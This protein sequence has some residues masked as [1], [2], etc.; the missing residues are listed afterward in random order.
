MARPRMQR[1]IHTPPMYSGFKPTG[2]MGRALEQLEMTL[3]EYEAMRLADLIGLSQEEAAR[4]MEISRPT[5]TRLIE[6]ARRKSAQ[7]LTQGRHLVI[8]GGPVH[9]RENVIR[10][11]DCGHSFVLDINR[12]INVCPSCG[13]GNLID[14]AGGYGH[15]RCCRHGQN[16]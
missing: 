16:R 7:F 4:E 13:S 14:L 8:G 5:F 9:F 10:C 6:A 11:H 15:G 3:D 1:M 2:V 12:D